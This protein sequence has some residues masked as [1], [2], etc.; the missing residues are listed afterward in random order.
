[1]PPQNRNQ[2]GGSRVVIDKS[3]SG[4]RNRNQTGSALSSLTHPRQGTETGSE[5]ARAARATPGMEYKAAAAAWTKTGTESEAVAAA[6]TRTETES[7]AAA[8]AQARTGGEPEAAAVPRVG[9]EEVKPGTKGRETRS[10][11][12]TG[13]VVV[14]GVVVARVVEEL[15][16]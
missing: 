1:M 5:A 2:R 3:P 8:A 4:S 15:R 10:D 6:R 11:A 7:K 14:A 13:A 9:A 12:A 16:A